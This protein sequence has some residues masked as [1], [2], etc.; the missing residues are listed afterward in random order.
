MMI[1]C[2]VLLIITRVLYILIANVYI[3]IIM[4]RNEVEKLLKPAFT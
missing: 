2:F 3:I 1:A 4:H